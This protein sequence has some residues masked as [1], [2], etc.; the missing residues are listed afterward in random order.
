MQISQRLFVFINRLFLNLIHLLFQIIKLCIKRFYKGKKTL[1]HNECYQ[2]LSGRLNIKRKQQLNSKWETI[3][4]DTAFSLYEAIL[5]A[6]EDYI[7]STKHSFAIKKGRS[8]QSQN[9]LKAVRKNE[10]IAAFF[11]GTFQKCWLNYLYLLYCI[12]ERKGSK[13]YIPK[14]QVLL[15]S[16]LL[17]NLHA[18]Q[19]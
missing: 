14:P 4:P 18:R 11:N 7:K 19:I 15:F 1:K 9:C 8:E 5:L 13:C 16:N 3:F 2:L 12:Q 17:L 6:R 10:E